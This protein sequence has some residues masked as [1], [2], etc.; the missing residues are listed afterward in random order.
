MAKGPGLMNEFEV[1]RG[2]RLTN[3]AARLE[4]DRQ[5]ARQQRAWQRRRR[6]SVKL[7]KAV[8]AEQAAGQEPTGEVPF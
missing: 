4:R 2:V 8:D 7:C 3:T 5:L 1:S 6:R